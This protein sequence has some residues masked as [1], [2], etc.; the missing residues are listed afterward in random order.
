M[1]GSTPANHA[2]R[3][4]LVSRRYP[5]P[6]SNEARRATDRPGEASGRI[7]GGTMEDASSGFPPGSLP[8]LPPLPVLPPEPG[9]PASPPAAPPE[10]AAATAADPA[11]SWPAVW[12]KLVTVAW[13]S[14]GVALALE[15]LLLVVAG[16]HGEMGTSPKPFVADLAQKISWGFI[17]CMG[18]AIGST[19]SK[20]RPA[21]MGFL[22]LIAAP[23]GFHAARAAHKGVGQA[24]GI[25]ATKAA[26]PIVLLSVVKAVEYG[27][28]GVAIAFVARRYKGSFRA[29]ALTGLAFGVLFGGAVLAVLAQ[30][31]PQPVDAY[32]LLSRGINEVLFP[33]CCSMVLY[34]GDAV[35][36]R[37]AR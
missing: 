9:P 2:D 10:P 28:L 13:L 15:V 1:I 23:L 4:L 7:I 37:L 27:M 31:S 19:V 30:S 17:A 6:R 21:A 33:V 5:G 34:A 18:L 29:Y 11:A 24:L 14:I 16:Y 36:Q 20:A 32:F 3:P 22:G 25:A 26:L 12:R 8:A 35:S